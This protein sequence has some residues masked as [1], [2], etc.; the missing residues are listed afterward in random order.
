MFFEGR[1][2]R[3]LEELRSNG[4][5]S[6]SE[7]KRVLGLS[8][9]TIRRDLTKLESLGLVQR[10]HGGAV[11]VSSGS[12]M[13]LS[14]FEKCKTN[15]DDKRR[16]GQRASEMVS[17]GDTLMLD[18]GTTTLQV[19][20]HIKDKMGIH[21]VTN[22]IYILLELAEASTVEVSL[23]GGDLRKISRSLIGPLA[24]SSI[25]AIN[26]DKVFLGATGISI[27][28]GLTSPNMIEAQTK[29]AMI[30][31][32]KN[33][34]LVADHTKFG[35][36]TLGKFAKLEDIQMLITDKKAPSG[37]IRAIVKRGVEVVQV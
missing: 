29:S 35:K 34:I 31:V 11:R 9:I 2:T 27:E 25:S 7:L 30:H 23:T 6:T 15:L 16:I 1:K 14:F 19:A 4:S 37:M 36:T 18:A 10:V 17:M 24:V 28:Q 33:V 12:A 22:S 8:E 20:K 21:V 3:I 5:I 13:E 26:V 32:A